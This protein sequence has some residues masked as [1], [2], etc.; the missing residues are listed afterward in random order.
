MTGESERE[1]L[2]QKI[3]YVGISMKDPRGIFL[4]LTSRSDHIYLEE[5]GRARAHTIPDFGC[6]LTNVTRLIN[7]VSREGNLMLIKLRV[8][9]QTKTIHTQTLYN[10]YH[11]IP[12]IISHKH[13][14]NI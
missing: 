12:T 13:F 3:S 10:I 9:Y 5:A 7:R 2:A 8:D 1:R 6:Y 11:T 14:K 4:A